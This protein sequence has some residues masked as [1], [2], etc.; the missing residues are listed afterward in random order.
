LN[1]TELIFSAKKMV[2]IRSGGIRLATA[3]RATVSLAGIILEIIEWPSLIPA[4][5]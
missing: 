1:I 5:P 4:L 2:S 3:K